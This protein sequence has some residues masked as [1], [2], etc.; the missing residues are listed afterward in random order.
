MK[1]Q[2]AK[3]GGRSQPVSQILWRRLQEGAFILLA[4]LSLFLMIGLCTYHAADPGWSH[5]NT[6][7]LIHNAAGVAG[8][9]FSDLCLYFF[10][11][12][13]YL[14]PLVISYSAIRLFQD[15]RALGSF[16]RWLWGFRI[17]G[18]MAAL[19]AGCGLAALHFKSWD[20]TLPAGVGGISGQFI[21]THALP[22]LGYV[23]ASLCLMAIFLVGITLTTGL[24]WFGLMDVIGTRCLKNLSQM[25]ARLMAWKQ[26]VRHWVAE[27]KIPFKPRLISALKPAEKPNAVALKAPRREPVFSEGPLASVSIAP[28]RARLLQTSNSTTTKTTAT[29][30]A[31]TQTLLDATMPELSLPSVTLLENNGQMMN[32]AI[33]PENDLQHLSRELEM[34]LLEFGVQVQVV[35]IAPGPVITQFELE[36]A[37]GVKVSKITG[38]SKDLARALS[39]N[40]VRVVEVIPGKSVVGLEIP[41]QNREMVLLREMLESREYAESASL[42][43][44][45]L[46]KDIS[47]NPV[48]VNLSKMPHLLVA[49]TTGSGKSIALNVMLLSLLYKATPEDVRLILIDPKMLELSI[50]E[51]I[52]HL[53]TPVVT[54]M[55]DAANALRWCVAEMEQRYQL[56]S[57]LGVRNLLGYNRKIQEANQQKKPL[58]DPFYDPAIGSERAVLKHL[59]YIVVIID[60]FADMMMVVGKKVEELIARIAQKARAAG[61]H[62]IL[63]TQRPSVDVITGL[64]KANIPTRIAFQVS[65]R[66]DSRTIL[67][68]QGAEQLLGHGDMLYLAPGAGIPVRVHGA[69]VSDEEVHAVVNALKALSSAYPS[70][71]VLDPQA[72]GMAFVG[73]EENAEGSE[74]DQHYDE[75]VRIVCESGRASISYLQRC[76]KIGYNRSARLIETMEKAGIVSP[77]QSNGSREVLVK[78]TL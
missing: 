70:I 29:V 42:L 32:T 36:L 65:S 33:R 46:G 9:W 14:F 50:Y 68:Q 48:V 16:H 61:I 60:E 66:I 39:V 21:N 3:S 30:V 74:Q 78:S 15:H 58:Y 38:L 18:F 45:A 27:R 8:A 35:S 34:K 12:V 64:I 43:T 53:L 76:L 10:G 67:D 20:K 75:A 52:P 26:R 55:K 7:T 13:A 54:D 6:P 11:Y 73:L 23:G 63:A 17:I 72:G 47:G 1:I 31:T 69:F 19:M 40:R 25:P 44:L 24:S 4:A 56:M 22:A 49:G 5:S 2:Q 41:N 71:D 57:A 62:L 51:G 59:P 37:P 28:T 77:L